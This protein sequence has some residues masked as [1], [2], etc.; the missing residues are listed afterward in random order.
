MRTINLNL[1]I[2]C[3][4][5]L[6]AC[7][8][9]CKK[10][11]EKKP[12][13]ALAVPTTI[14]DCQA[15]L[16]YNYTI[17]QYMNNGIGEGSADNYYLSYADWAALYFQSDKN[18]YVWGDEIFFDNPPGSNDWS[19]LY[20][21]PYRS[22]VV[23]EALKKIQANAQTQGSWNNV[24]GSAFFLRAWA[25]HVL[26]VDFAKAYD[27]TTANSDLGI[28]LRL[29]SDFNQVSVRASVQQSYS[30]IIADLKAAIPLLPANPSHV[31]R[32][33]KIAAYA[34]L[35]RVYLSMRDYVK[36]GL[37]A[38]SSLQ[39]NGSLLDY[40]TLSGTI[41]IFNQEVIFHATGGSNLLYYAKVDSTLIQ[42][43]SSDDLRKSIFFL[44]NGNGTYGWKSSYDGTNYDLFTGIA[45]D[46]MY[47]TRAE[48]YAKQGNTTLAMQDLNILM[49]KRWKNNGTWVP[50]TAT[51]A[52]DALNKIRTERRKEFAWRDLRWMDIKRLNK[53]GANIT[54]KRILNGQTYTLPPNDNRFALPFPAA[55]IQIS[56]MPQNPR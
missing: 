9:S 22:N 23:L 10:Y 28:P 34:L 21:L 19:N 48:C 24:A 35:S 56:G 17:N 37:Y 15:I 50:L 1:N 13:K 20:S 5:I 46:E 27:N 26:A 38:D 42:S 14:E 4:S 18:I 53:E 49:Q 55:V 12:D 44:D 3:L 40:A 54:L 30:Q 39:L 47:L 29:N 33:S 8:I 11:L 25:F 43:Y 51:D 41:P 52:T 36:A 7:F 2:L 16:D 45:T 31:M 6:F 32:P